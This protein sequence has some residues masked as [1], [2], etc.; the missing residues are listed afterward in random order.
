[1]EALAPGAPMRAKGKKNQKVTVSGL[2]PKPS[3]GS[4]HQ[5]LAPVLG[6]PSL[7]IPLPRLGATSSP[8]L[9]RGLPYLCRPA[10]LL[11]C[12]GC[13]WIATTHGIPAPAWAGTGEKER[14]RDCPP[15]SPIT[16]PHVKA[17]LLP[18][19]SW[20][21]GTEDLSQREGN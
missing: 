18:H 3:P 16:L 7:R 10:C 13:K 21:A 8:L 17:S 9:P 12:L 19:P 2:S 11:A 4:Q 5:A 14:G 6:F 1:M 20:R 15:D